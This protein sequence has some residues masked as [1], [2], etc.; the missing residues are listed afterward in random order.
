MSHLSIE[1]DALLSLQTSSSQVT[2]FKWHHFQFQ[3]EMIL[4]C[5]RLISEI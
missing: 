2:P 4:L 5:I 1:Q 3:A